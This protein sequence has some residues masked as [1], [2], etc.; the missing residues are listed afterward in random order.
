MLSEDVQQKTC[1]HSNLCFESSVR[2]TPQAQGHVIHP[3]WS[4]K[5]AL[6][7]YFFDFHIEQLHSIL[8][9]DSG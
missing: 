7:S 1:G 6:R 2:L 5:A 9:W 3:N 8:S 4:K